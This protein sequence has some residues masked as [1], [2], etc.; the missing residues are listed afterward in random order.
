MELSQKVVFYFWYSSL[1]GIS[2]K[3][4]PIMGHEAIFK[5]E[6]LPQVEDENRADSKVVSPNR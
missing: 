4:Y 5:I 2:T 6:I 3:N 1:G